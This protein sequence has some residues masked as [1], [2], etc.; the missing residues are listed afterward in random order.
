MSFYEKELRK[1]FENRRFASEKKFV[2]R[3]CV[4]K[5]NEVF[6][7]KLTLADS[8]NIE[9][10]CTGLDVQIIHR[11]QGVID[12]QYI[13]FESVWGLQK[14]KSHPNPVIPYIYNNGVDSPDWYMFKP[15]DEH[16]NM[17]AKYV[18]YYV[19]LYK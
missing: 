5:I 14:V 2:G 10:T 8:N 6:V 3:S 18:S 4:G 16:Y 15:T 9:G 17:F 12:R 19:T 11:T 13:T 1:M 7:V